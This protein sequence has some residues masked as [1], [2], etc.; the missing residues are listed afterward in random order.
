MDDAAY[1]MLAARFNQSLAIQDIDG[2]DK[3]ALVDMRG[4]KTWHSSRA[5]AR[6]NDIFPGIQ[7]RLRGMQADKAHA[8]CNKNHIDEPARREAG[9]LFS[10][11]TTLAA[12]QGTSSS[13]L[14]RCASSYDAFLDVSVTTNGAGSGCTSLGFLSPAPI[15]RAP[16]AGVVRMGVRPED[17]VDLRPEA[18]HVIGMAKGDDLAGADRPSKVGGEGGDAAVARRVCGSE[19][20]P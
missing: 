7:E 12:I 8:T 11:K 13:S 6:E 19:H 15:Q 16:D 1:R 9:T 18:A 20:D 4:E 17:V 14:S 3:K 5:E 10:A 2:L